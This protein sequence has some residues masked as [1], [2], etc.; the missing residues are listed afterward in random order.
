MV[1]EYKL[2]DS[3]SYVATGFHEAALYRWEYAPQLIPWPKSVL[4]TSAPV[5]GRVREGD[6][7]VAVTWKEWPPASVVA[8][9]VS[10]VPS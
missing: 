5:S 3:A 6:E 8:A 2:T 9:I 1:V 10:C 4:V 7:V